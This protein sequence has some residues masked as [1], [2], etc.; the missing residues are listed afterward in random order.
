MSRRRKSGDSSLELLLDTICNTF[1]G[2]LFL[3]MLVSLMLAQTRRSTDATVA[4]PAP[5]VSAAELQRLETRSHDSAH[6]LAALEEQARQARRAAGA[7]AVPDADELLVAMEDAEHRAGD[8]E[9]RRTELLATLVAHQA[10]SARARKALATTESEQ[11][12]LAVEADRARKRLADAVDEREAI[13]A[14][15]VEIRDEAT[16]RAT[17]QTT[18]RTPLAR[19][20]DRQQFALMVRYGRLYL[21]KKMRGGQLVVNEEDFTLTPGIL[22]NVARAKPHAGIDLSVTTGR[23]AALRRI[24]ADF[25]PSLWYAVLVVHPDSFEEYITVKNWLVEQGYNLMPLPTDDIVTD[26]GSP[27]NQRMQ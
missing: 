5:A 23:D 26:S 12:R 8:A 15:A 19:V 9:A 22:W 21:I 16:R 2:I 3:A 10:A 14:S 18:G 11:R 27:E 6:G 4:D 7:L 24:T 20:P 1:G 17:V 25:P 13:V